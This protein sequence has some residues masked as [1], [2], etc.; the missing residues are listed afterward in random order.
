MPAAHHST[1]INAPLAVVMATITDFAAYPSFLP[2]M[3]SAEVLR[4]GDGVWEV[5]FT[6]SLI[7]ELVY[8]LKLTAVGPNLLRWT[9]L[10][11]AFRSNEGSWELTPLDD[12]ARTR[13][14]YRIDLSV[15]IY[16]PGNIIRSLV[17]R[18]LPDTLRRFKAEAE[19]RAK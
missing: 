7:R 11:G 2:D 1:E 13:A 17:D 6:V 9:L 14:D 18:G 16:V 15:G 5:R 4:Q 3:R 10:E 19:R 12:G 8:T